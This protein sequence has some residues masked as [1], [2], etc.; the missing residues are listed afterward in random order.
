MKQ[1]SQK[2]CLISLLEPG[3][4]LGNVKFSWKDW[5]LHVTFVGVHFAE[6]NNE[7]IEEFGRLM[8]SFQSFEARTLNK[9]RLGEGETAAEVV[10]VEN[11][12]SIT[13]LHNL[14]MDFL[15]SHNAEFNNP[16]WT[17]EGNI[18]HSTIQKHAQVSENDKIVIDNIAL[19]D[20]F[21]DGDGYMRKI[22]KVFSLKK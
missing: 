1:F 22:M 18:P 12:G 16:E 21:P 19:I 5:V 8:E 17:R 7:M 15:D 11:K 6:W 3:D 9:G 14:I 20:M 13:E 4:E 10:F 2:Y